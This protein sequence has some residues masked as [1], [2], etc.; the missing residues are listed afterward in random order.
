MI[1]G[2]QHENTK[3]IPNVRIVSLVV[4]STDKAKTN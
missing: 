1:Y 4:F 3:A 2:K